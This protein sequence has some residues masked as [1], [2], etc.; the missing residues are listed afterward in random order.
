MNTVEWELNEL[1]CPSFNISRSNSHDWYV[2]RIWPLCTKTF[3]RVAYLLCGKDTKLIMFK[4]YMYIV[5]DYF[6]FILSER[7]KCMWFKKKKRFV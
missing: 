6:Y 2:I 5:N 7:E 1:K 4:I 3:W